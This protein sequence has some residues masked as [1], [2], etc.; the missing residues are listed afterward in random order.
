MTSGTRTRILHK[1]FEAMHLQ[2]FQGMR[3]DKVMQ[4]LGITKGAFY[5]YFRTKH[6]LG[7][8]IVEE[9]LAPQYVQAWA[10]LASASENPLN[11]IVQ[12]LEEL[13]ETQDSDRIKLGCPLNNLVQ[14][15]SPLDEGFRIRLRRIFDQMQEGVSLGI[16]RG[17]AQGTVRKDVDAQELGIFIIA[18]L[19]GAFSIAKVQQ[20]LEVFQQAIRQL[21]S[22]VRSLAAT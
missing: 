2:G 5:H 1:N 7:Y 21:A 4:D 9:I 18:A 16:M 15:M 10:R 13:A 17:Q 8:A 20:S 14:E 19:E 22:F 6:E 12:H 3:T 11:M